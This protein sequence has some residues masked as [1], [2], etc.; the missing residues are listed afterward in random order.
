M[1]FMLIRTHVIPRL[2]ISG[3]MDRSSIVMAI[4]TVCVTLLE[5]I[6]VDLALEGII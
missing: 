5:D 2:T 6:W 4:P 1:V 3:F